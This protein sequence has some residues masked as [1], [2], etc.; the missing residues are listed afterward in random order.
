MVT[1]S[2]ISLFILMG[3]LSMGV[4]LALCFSGA[5][6]YMSL[7]GGVTMKGMMLWGLQQI[8]SPALLCIPLFI[9]A[10]SLMSE[11][12]IAKYLLDFVDV[13]VGRIRGGLGV[14]ATVTC[15]LIGAISGS[16][17]TGVAATGNMLI[18][19]MVKRGYPRPFATALVT[20][21]SILGVLIPPSTPMIIFG[22]VTGTSVL[23]CFLSTVGPGLLTTAI[24]CAINLVYARKFPLVIPPAITG[25]EKFNQAVSKGWK[26]L[27][28]LFMPVLILGG[29]YGGVMTP[30]E[31]AAAAVIYS[32][33][34]G[35]LVYKGLTPRTFMSVTKDSGVS[36]GSIMIMIMCSMML[37]QTYV[38]L[39]IPQ[40]IVKAVFS[41]TS[42]RVMILILIN[43]LLLFVGMIVND[44]T[45]IILVAPL[46]M[47]LAQA[48]GLHPIQYA[49]IFCVNLAIG[50]LTPPYA[51][52]LYLGM[53]IGKV[54]FLDILPP[55]G[56]FLLGYV[57]VMILT[58][59]WPA[60]SL[61]LPRM[62]GF[63]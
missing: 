55:L 49:A 58:T 16:A 13:F 37:S 21:S 4:P 14:V 25:R 33:P 3:L 46:L 12:G 61:T 62:M 28:A 47:P 51:S 34:V 18:P 63:L 32:V 59:Y 5:L 7:A 44:V 27:P 60:L 39:Q 11:S 38:V 23:A 52:L 2:I 30:T 9:Y 40:L 6:F 35:F 8:L 15:A 10:G 45:G 1:V 19:E 41:L 17:F 48:I 24:F 42:N 53:R 29:I 56:I 50:S 57:P 31:A 54:E 26:A 36:T 43:L 22:W 20:S